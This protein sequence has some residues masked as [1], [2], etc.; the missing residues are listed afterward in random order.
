[1][2]PVT[3]MTPAGKALF[4]QPPEAFALAL[5]GCR[6]VSRIGGKVTE[7]RIVEAEAYLAVGDPAAHAARGLG[8]ALRALR[9]GPGTLYIHPMRGRCGLDIVCAGGSVLIRAAEPLQGLDAMGARRGT[10]DPLRL[11]RGPACLTEALGIT[12]ALDG[13][14]LFDPACPLRLIA[15]EEAGAGPRA[16]GTTPRIGL[17]RAADLPLRFAV[18]GSRFVSARR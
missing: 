5:L 8:A 9:Q 2:N 1:M 16:I 11:M 14:S 6:I 7:G 15:E 13:V 12:R 17:A 10:N 3:D 4:H 18:T